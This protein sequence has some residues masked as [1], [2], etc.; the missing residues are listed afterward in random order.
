M[1]D[2]QPTR[3]E[4]K[5]RSF[6]AEHRDADLLVCTGYTSVKGLVWLSRHVDSHQKVTL[7][8]GDMT[9]SNFTRATEADRATASEFLRGS[10]VKVHNWYRSK[11]TK[12]I[13]HGKAIVA[14]R[15]GK[16][17]AALVGSANLT[18][19]GLSNNLELM[20]R[21]HPDDWGDIQAYLDEATR[22]PPA[23]TKLIGLVGPDEDARTPDRAPAAAGS[24][25]LGALA[26]LPIQ[27]AVKRWN[28]LSFRP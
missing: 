1:P 27:A 14:K 28:R 23:N 2:G 19:T 5:I 12:K 11:P 18:E 22:H 3:T 7:I 21:C 20:V 25:C 16:T 15:G 6:L 13:A 4:H 8:I 17:V 9:P 10:N 26:L 24:G